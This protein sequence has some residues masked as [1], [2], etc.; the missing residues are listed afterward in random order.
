MFRQKDF[1][2]FYPAFPA[3]V[4][5]Q[6]VPFIGEG[7]AAPVGGC[8]NG[9]ASAVPAYDFDGKMVNCH[10]WLQLLCGL[11]G[12]WFWVFG[13]VFFCCG[14]FGSGLLACGFVPMVF[15]LCRSL[16]RTHTWPGGSGISAPFPIK[17]RRDLLS[18]LRYK[19]DGCR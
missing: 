6:P 3:V 19:S 12:F 18:Q 9:R 15:A 17:W 14:S 1:R 16:R 7:I 4:V 2:V 10:G 5:G 8:G 13:L 11:C